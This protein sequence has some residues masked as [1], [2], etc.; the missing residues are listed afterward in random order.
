MLGTVVVVA[1]WFCLAIALV[2]VH[3]CRDDDTRGPPGLMA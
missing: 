1:M 2:W 3:M